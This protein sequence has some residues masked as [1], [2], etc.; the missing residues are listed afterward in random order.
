MSTSIPADKARNLIISLV[1]L[2]LSTFAYV[3]QVTWLAYTLLS[4]YLLSLTILLM[5]FMGI[6]FYAPSRKAGAEAFRANMQG[7]LW[8]VL[9][10]LVGTASSLLLFS[11][12]VNIDS[13][14]I[15]ATVG[16]N[17]ILGH[18]YTWTLYFIVKGN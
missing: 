5:A 12:G 9:T 7:K 2:A 6:L 4:I 3:N 18:L 11:Y 10:M 1:V 15:M 14:F 17:F 16:T 8:N 13:L